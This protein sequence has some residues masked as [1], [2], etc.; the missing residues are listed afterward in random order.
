[1]WVKHGKTRINHPP[2]IT[3]FIGGMLSR[4]GSS[5]SRG[6]AETA[7]PWPEPCFVS[8]CGGHCFVS[9]GNQRPLDL[10]YLDTFKSGWVACL[11]IQ[12]GYWHV[13]S[14]H[15]SRCCLVPKLMPSSGL[16]TMLG[17]WVRANQSFRPSLMCVQNSPLFHL[18]TGLAALL[19]PCASAPIVRA[20][21]GMFTIPSHGWF[22]AL[23]YPHYMK[24]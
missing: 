12:W 11:W 16:W 8:H 22:M 14:D 21:G 23:F 4:D 24:I 18:K 2:V 10:G 15:N 20:I 7:E 3:I 1:M 19:P 5:P 17:R 6:A 9:K 13:G